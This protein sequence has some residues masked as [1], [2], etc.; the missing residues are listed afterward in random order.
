MALADEMFGSAPS[1]Y[2]G[3]FPVH[4]E[5]T[6]PQPCNRQWRL[7]VGIACVFVFVSRKVRGRVSSEM[8]QTQVGNFEDTVVWRPAFTTDNKYVARADVMMPTTLL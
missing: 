8:R 3:M 6:Q 5:P 1:L 2:C 4:L 7:T